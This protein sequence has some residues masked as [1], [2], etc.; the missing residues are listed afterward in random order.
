MN[1]NDTEVAVL[2][3]HKQ[4]SS[5]TIRGTVLGDDFCEERQDF[6][7][8]FFQKCMGKSTWFHLHEKK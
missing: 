7:K 4:F 3:V 5:C 8:S 1:D 6:V 2:L